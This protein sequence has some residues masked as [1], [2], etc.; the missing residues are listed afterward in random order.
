M[1]YRESD[2]LSWFR[3]L[4]SHPS[5]K[6]E[7]AIRSFAHQIAILLGISGPS[8]GWFE[9]ADRYKAANAFND[10]CHAHP[11]L[12]FGQ[13]EDPTNWPSPCE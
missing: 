9:K 3:V 13:D 5:P 11:E 8:I 7:L 6:F 2:G 12:N 10:C 1:N 4:K